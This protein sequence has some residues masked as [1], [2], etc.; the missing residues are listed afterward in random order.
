MVVSGV[1]VMMQVASEP[2]EVNLRLRPNRRRTAVV[3]MGSDK[4]VN[5]HR[6]GV[7]EEGK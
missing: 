5:G 7:R 6:G 2:V 3:Q 1:R 4:A